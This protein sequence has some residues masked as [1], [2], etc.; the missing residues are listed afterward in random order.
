[1]QGIETALNEMR[2]GSA[3]RD[4]SAQDLREALG[5]FATGIAV[6]TAVA[7]GGN[8]IG[9]TVSS[10]N[11]VS[12]DPP[13]VLFSMARSSRAFAAWQSVIHFAVNVLSEGQDALSSKFARALGDKWEGARCLEGET[14]APL[15]A[16]SLA[17]FECARLQCSRAQARRR[18][19]ADL[20]PQQVPAAGGR[21]LR[22]GAAR[23]RSIAARVVASRGRDRHYAARNVDGGLA[24]DLV[25]VRLMI[26]YMTTVV[27]CGMSC[28]RSN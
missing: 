10:F 6:V 25:A 17:A 2:T 1:V 22:R 4:F 12:L 7:D 8:R 11:S 9:A 14:G 20:L 21:G 27:I 23:R 15:L 19:T 18:G 13:L 24:R 3:T 16:D 28:A 5:F 26:M